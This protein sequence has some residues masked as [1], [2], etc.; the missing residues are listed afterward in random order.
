[1]NP[2]PRLTRTVAG[3]CETIGVASVQGDTVAVY[4]LHMSRQEVQQREVC[5]LA[6]RSNVAPSKHHESR[7]SLHL[8]ALL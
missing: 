1:M 6:L 3:V 8:P 5:T 7:F 2:R 4:T